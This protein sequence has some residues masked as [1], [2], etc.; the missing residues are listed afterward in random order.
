MIAW[1]HMITPESSFIPYHIFSTPGS[2]HV[3]LSFVFQICSLFHWLQHCC[4]GDSEDTARMNTWKGGYAYNIVTRNTGVPTGCGDGLE[5]DRGSILRFLPL[6]LPLSIWLLIVSWHGQ[7][8]NCPALAALSPPASRFAIW[9]IFVEWLWHNG[10]I[11]TTL[12]HIR[13]QI[14]E[15]LS[16]RKSEFGRWKSD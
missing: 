8:L 2:L 12:A 1:I 7:N 10:W 9:L 14:N 3:Y 4:V 16:D 13:P 15:Y 6:W 5:P 11:Q